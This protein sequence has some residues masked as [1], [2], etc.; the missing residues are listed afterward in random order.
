MSDLVADRGVD[1]LPD[2]AAYAT[3]AAQ[4]RPA[5]PRRAATPRAVARDRSG[6]GLAG[7]RRSA[8][9]EAAVETGDHL[10]AARRSPTRSGP[11]WWLVRALCA[12]ALVMEVWGSQGIF[13]LT[14]RGS[15]RGARPI[16]VSL[17]V[18]DRP[19][20][21]VARHHGS[22]R[23]LT[24]RLVV[25]GAERVRGGDAPGDVRPVPGPPPATT[26]LATEGRPVYPQTPQNGGRPAPGREHLRPTTPG[27]TRSSASSS[28][29]RT[30]AGSRSR[31]SRTR[32]TRAQAPHAPG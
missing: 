1:A 7:P 25:I 9:G 26:Q 15:P 10:G 18:P 30:V 6:L 22:G 14:L 16:S 28:S 8:P 5:S 2:P 24:L 4:R 23:S 11:A 19:G 20:G 21:V 27:A 12:A 31:S 17:S 13:G 32:T 3:R 29:T